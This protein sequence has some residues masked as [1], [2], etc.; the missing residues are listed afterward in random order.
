M[1]EK[2]RNLRVR[3]GAGVGI[4]GVEDTVMSRRRPTA[5][6]ASLAL[7]AL[8]VAGTAGCRRIRV[9]PKVRPKA[10][11]KVTRVVPRTRRAVPLGRAALRHEALRR[12]QREDARR[13]GR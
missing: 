6:L 10:A 2:T 1:M 12:Q 4:G 9:K 5:A 3:S 8:L 7:L 13:R 11:P